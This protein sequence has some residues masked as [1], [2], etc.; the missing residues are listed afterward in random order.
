MGGVSVTGCSDFV[1]ESY[2]NA[3][4]QMTTKTLLTLCEFSG[5]VSGYII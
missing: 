5:H 2:C 1:D 3:R 4:K